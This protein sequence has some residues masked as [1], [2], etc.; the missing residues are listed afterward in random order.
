MISQWEGFEED[1]HDHAHR[2]QQ[3]LLGEEPLDLL[4]SIEPTAQT[5]PC[6]AKV[7]FTDG[8]ESLILKD[9]ANLSAPVAARRIRLHLGLVR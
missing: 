9:L 8:T 4:L 7:E 6:G 3:G 5:E 2:L 1:I